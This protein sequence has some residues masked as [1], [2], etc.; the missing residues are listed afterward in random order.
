L[1]FRAPLLAKKSDLIRRFHSLRHN[2]QMQAFS[3]PNHRA[4][5]AGSVAIR[6]ELADEGLIDLQ[7]VDRKALQVA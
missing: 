6:S 5:D 4:D 2:P 7:S 1:R 3:H